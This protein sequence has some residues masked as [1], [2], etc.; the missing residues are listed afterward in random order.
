M[1]NCAVDA[2][3]TSGWL[4]GQSSDVY[5]TAELIDTLKSEVSAALE[6]LYEADTVA[7]FL[8]SMAGYERSLEKTWHGVEKR[9]RAKGEWV[10][11]E[12]EPE[13]ALLPMGC[14]AEPAVVRSRTTKE[15]KRRAQPLISSIDVQSDVF[16]KRG[17]VE[18]EDVLPEG[19]A[20][21]IGK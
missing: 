8:R 7:T 17:A 11:E 10:A 20:S 12:L 18:G 16:A 15:G 13:E 2:I 9:K 14:K 1:M 6:G 19:G 4:I 21:R 3:G 5:G